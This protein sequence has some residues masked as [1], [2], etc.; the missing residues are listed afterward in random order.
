[1]RGLMPFLLTASAFGGIAAAHAQT[2]TT[3]AQTKV[4][5]TTLADNGNDEQIVVTGS[6]IARANIDAAI[7]ITTLSV[8]ELTSNTGSVSVG[9]ILAHLP[10][11]RATLTTSNSTRNI[12]TAGLIVLDLRGLGAS[13]TLVVVNGRRHVTSQPGLQSVDVN[14]IPTDLLQSV[15]IVTGGNSAVYG[16]DAVAGVVN[17]VLKQDFQ[18]LQG[19]FQGGISSRGDRASSLASVTAGK[20]FAEGRGNIAANFEFSQQDALYYIERDEQ[21]GG[22]TGRH[23]FV[24]TQNTIGQPA[25]G[26]GIPVNTFY[27]GGIRNLNISNGGL[28][29]SACPA[30][31]ATGESQASF[32]ARRAA[33][34]TGLFAPSTPGKVGAE[35]GRTYVFDARG[36]LVPN[37]PTIDFRPFGS[38]NGLGGQGSTL[39]ESSQLDPAVTKYAANIIGHYEFSRALRFFVEAKY[40]RVDSIQ[41]GQPTFFNNVFSIN[42][43]YLSSQARAVLLPSLPPGATT[44][45]AQRFNTDFGGRGEQH[46]RDLY[47]IVGG[48]QGTFLDTWKYEL[49]FNYGRV[50]TFYQTQ[51]NVVLTKYQNSLNAARDT[52]GNIVCSINATPGPL[53]DPACVPVN[54][55]GSGNVSQAA[56]NYFGIAS[57]RVQHAEQYDALATVSGDSAKLFSLPGGPIGFAFGTEYRRETAFSKYDDLTASGATFLNSIPTFKPPALAVIEGFAEVRLPIIKDRPFVRELSIE[58]AARVSNYNIGNT[59]TVVAYNAGGVYAPIRD[60]RIR[61][62]Y[63]VS[64]R[65]PTQNDLYASSSQ[66]FLN[67]LLDPCG[68]LNINANPNRVKNCLAAG[69][70]TTQTFNGTTEPFTNVPTSGISGLNGSN[71]KLQAEEGTSYTIG[72]V[73]QPHW[74]RGLAITLDYFNIDVKNQINAL[75]PQIIINQ[76]YDSPV[77]INNPFCAAISRNPNGTFLGQSNVAHGGTSVSF[78]TTGQSFLAQPFNYARQNTSGIDLDVA[79]ARALTP[80]VSV[81]GRV[82]LSWLINRDSYSVISDPTFRIQQKLTLGDPEWKGTLDFGLKYKE[83]E[84]NYQFRY[85]GRQT[86]GLYELQN[87]VDGRPPQRANAFPNIYYPDITY[88]NFRLGINVDKRYQFYAGVDNAFDQFPPLG[89][90]G[91][92]NTGTTV[93]GSGI[94]DNIGRTV[95]AGI[96][97]KY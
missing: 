10:S 24:Q 20:N 88:S 15:D 22:I 93:G 9:D 23:Q 52:T 71:P 39:F 1:M 89:L 86:I 90:D 29:A 76:C 68:A 75:A 38:Q 16:S 91:T 19:H 25:A 63:A 28:Y 45:S 97:F 6:R 8:G 46:N 14:T 87:T 30:A 77:G 74:V 37:N 54:L 73:F 55:F 61:G 18:G 95:Y 48:F 94:Y 72:G 43:P 67:G 36:N 27:G 79:Y 11:L 56:L 84:L 78:P 57:S 80:D 83:F 62:S 7:P 4:S 21:Y 17:F 3:G 32:L 26:N 92:G 50:D 40:V 51:G 59:G 58:S 31:P 5:G 12:G 34:C 49:S 44:F 85:I 65:A 35:F 60:L 33:S 53:N 47:R 42:N 82:L 2:A 66:T 96:L 41:A 70:P 69:V 81:N 13:R 64:V